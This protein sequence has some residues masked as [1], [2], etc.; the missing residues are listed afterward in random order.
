MDRCFGAGFHAKDRPLRLTYMHLRSF[1]NT[2]MLSD[3]KEYWEHHFELSSCF[4]DLRQFVQRLPSKDQKDFSR[5]ITNRTRDIC[6]RL[7]KDE[8]CIFIKLNTRT[9]QVDI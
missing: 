2:P 7:G 5:F 6:A 3:C 1:I 8:V 9:L 4:T